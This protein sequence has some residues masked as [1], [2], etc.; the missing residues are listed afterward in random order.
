MK[1]PN[2]NT[3]QLLLLPQSDQAPA[4]LPAD[5]QRDLGSA[6]RELLLRAAVARGENQPER[7]RDD[8]SETHA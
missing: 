2:R 6:L 7:Q 4:K 5:R 1:Q 3:L 8:K